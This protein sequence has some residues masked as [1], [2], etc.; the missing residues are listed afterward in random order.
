MPWKLKSFCNCHCSSSSSSHAYGHSS[1]SSFVSPGLTNPEARSFTPNALAL[2][3]CRCPRPSTGACCISSNEIMQQSTSNIEAQ[4][5]RESD[6][7]PPS[8]CYPLYCRCRP[9]GLRGAAML[10]CCWCRDNILPPRVP[11]GQ[12]CW[13]AQRPGLVEPAVCHRPEERTQHCDPLFAANAMS[14]LHAHV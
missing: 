6:R 8:V 12:L 9:G 11:R 13:R 14:V 2:A 4:R 1:A 7:P 3:G 5:N 10:Q